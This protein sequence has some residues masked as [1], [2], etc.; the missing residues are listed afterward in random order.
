MKYIKLYNFTNIYDSC[1]LQIANYNSDCN[2]LIDGKVYINLSDKK[3]KEV[4]DYHFNQ[5]ADNILKLTLGE[6]VLITNS[7]T[8]NVKI[9]DHV[10][11]D[12]APFLKHIKKTWHDLK[13]KHRKNCLSLAVPYN[14]LETSVIGII[15][16]NFIEKVQYPTYIITNKEKDGSLSIDDMN[17]IKKKLYTRNYIGTL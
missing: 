16:E 5:M 1:L 8:Y 3:I 6:K 17:K 12:K 13:M 10:I 2:L 9:T 11:L 7:T 15:G 14:I 4:F